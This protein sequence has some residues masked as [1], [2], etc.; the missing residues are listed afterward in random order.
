VALHPAFKAEE[1]ERIRKQRLVAILQEGDQPVLSALRVGRRRSMAISRMAFRRWDDGFGEGDDAQSDLRAFWAA[2][3]G[4]KGCG[5]DLCRG[6]D[7]SEA[8][9]WRRSISAAGAASAAAARARCAACAP[10]R[11][12]V[13][14]WTSR[15]R[16]RRR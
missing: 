2:H 4:P 13:I 16:R 8:K 5:A 15:V 9:R 1:V 11:K 3:Y 12:V 10:E 6:L 14:W 7:G